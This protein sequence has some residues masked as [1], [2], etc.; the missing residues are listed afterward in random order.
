MP[1]LFEKCFLQNK[2]SKC[3]KIWKLQRKYQRKIFKIHKKVQAT[4]CQ[5][6]KNNKL[7]NYEKI[8]HSNHIYCLTSTSINMNQLQ[9]KSGLKWHFLSIYGKQNIKFWQKDR[10][11]T[12][13]DFIFEISG[14]SSLYGPNLV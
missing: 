13:S 5:Q 10:V 6:P 11:L 2:L 12:K 8:F 9:K 1:K 3:E 4:S 7:T 14:F